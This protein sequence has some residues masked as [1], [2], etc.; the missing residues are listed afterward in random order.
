MVQ[1]QQHD[2]NR[3]RVDTTLR[4]NYDSERAKGS[5]RK[6]GK[7][8]DFGDIYLRLVFSVPVF[9]SFLFASFLNS[10]IRHYLISSTQRVNKFGMRKFYSLSVGLSVLF[11]FLCHII[12][13]HSITECEIMKT[14][15]STEM[16]TVR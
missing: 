14:S 10:H 12:A 8:N 2:K 9:N 1:G 7:G 15:H 13:S 11:F 4:E 5:F 6:H 3:Y 16:Q